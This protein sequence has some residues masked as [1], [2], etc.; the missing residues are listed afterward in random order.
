LIV[1][2]SL[3]SPVGSFAAADPKK[4]TFHSLVAGSQI[5]GSNVKNLQ[6]ET[7]G[8]IDEMLVDP[9]TGLTRFLI[10]SVGG[11]LKLGTTKN[12]Y[13]RLYTR[14]TAEPVYVYWREEWIVEPAPGTAPGT[15][16]GAT[17]AR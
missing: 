13:E 4:D 3:S 11:F 7:I 17:P 10:L 5:K 16:P 2:L 14:E 12:T 1:A 9:P 15:A 8:E 6:G